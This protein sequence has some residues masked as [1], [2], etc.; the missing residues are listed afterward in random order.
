MIVRGICCLRVGIPEVSE[1]IHI[2][3]IVGDFLEHSR[4]FYFYNGGQEEYYMGSAD[5]MPRNMD[6]RVE[7][8]FPVEEE[9][10]KSMLSYVLQVLLKDN[11]KAYRKLA[12]GSYERNATGG[13]RMN[14]QKIF[15]EDNFGYGSVN[16]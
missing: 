10:I 2:T 14:A 13:E 1:H 3:S 11:V 6:R 8:I 9:Q 7:L 16:V 12:D 5:W 4:I 15:R